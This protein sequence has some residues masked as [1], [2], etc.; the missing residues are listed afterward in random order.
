MHEGMQYDPIEGQSREA[1]KVG[2][3][4]IFKRYLLGHLQC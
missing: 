4:S 1:L 3:A 2:N